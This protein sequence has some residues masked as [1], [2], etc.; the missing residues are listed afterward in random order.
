MKFF[1]N[2][3]GNIKKAD[4]ELK[5]LN[6]IC[7]K[8]NT[9][10]TYLAYTIYGIMQML[11][12]SEII[13]NEKLEINQLIETD[14]NFYDLKDLCSDMDEQT[15]KYIKNNKKELCKIFSLTEED[16]NTSEIT[17]FGLNQKKKNL[18]NDDIL[19]INHKIFDIMLDESS[20]LIVVSMIN[21]ELSKKLSINLIE[22]SLNRLLSSFLMSSNISRVI[23]IT[24][25]RIGIAVF[26]KDLDSNRT[27]IIDYIHK[28]QKINVIDMISKL[29]S[30]YMAPIQHNIEFIRDYTALCK[31]K[32][33]LLSN[34]CEYGNLIISAWN[35]LLSGKINYTQDLISYT[36]KK[37]KVTIPLY[38]ASSF[39]KS[40]LILDLYLRH[41]AQK[42][43][44]LIIDEPELNLH[45]D[46]QLELCKIFSLLIK[47]GIKII[48]ST[49]SDYII[50]EINNLIK[51]NKYSSEIEPIVQKQNYSKHDFINYDD[52]AIFEVELNGSVNSLNISVDG[53]E[54]D[55]FNEV[56]NTQN[57]M[58][59]NL[60]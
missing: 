41:F 45:P 31:R 56:I 42:D 18:A 3:I 27:Q 51:L 44:I 8:N 33:Y 54:I 15:N 59:V 1:I 38:A 22:K 16:L 11:R 7:G 12:N 55:L 48:I 4:I 20:D 13:D 37:R 28:N 34:D 53:F 10:K 2:N 43:D 50:R 17:V 26:Y 14:T 30:R 36:D 24:S 52:V 9:G 23:P 29:T 39:V 6:I 60:M 5:K 32:S 49:H 58:F 46:K 47:A 40:F 19:S 35:K 21:Q 25:E 57:E